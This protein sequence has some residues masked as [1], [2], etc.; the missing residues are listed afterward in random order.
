MLFIELT[1]SHVLNIELV[2][3]SNGGYLPNCCIVYYSDH[4]LNN[5]HLSVIQIVNWIADILSSIQIIGTGN[6]IWIADT[7]L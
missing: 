3:Y 5:R 4:C 7:K 6:L 1:D 2:R